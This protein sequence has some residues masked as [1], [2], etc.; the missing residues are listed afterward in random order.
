LTLGTASTTRGTS[1][2]RDT[3]FEVG[4][5]TKLFTGLLL[6]DMAV[7]G[8]LALDDPVSTLLPAGVEPPTRDGREPTLRELSSHMSGL[9]RLPGNLMPADMQDPYAGYTTEAM[10]EFVSG[11]A[12]PGVP[13]ESFEYSNLGVGL[14]GD[15]LTRRAGASYAGLLEDRVTGPLGLDRTHV[16]TSDNDD[17]AAEGHVSGEVV[18]YWHMDAL[19]AAGEVRSTPADMLRFVRAQLDPAGTPL[20]ETIRLT[21]E[22]VPAVDQLSMGLGWHV[23][24]LPDGREIYFHNGGTGGFRSFAGFV[25]GTGVGLVIL[26][27]AAFP[28]EA[29][30]QAGVQMLMAVLQAQ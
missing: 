15:L 25:P 7:R 8:E 10:Y 2:T 19:K 12:L 23:V 26:A 24:A 13:G 30:D 17:T 11:L 14:L 28:L 29:I 1:V 4:S 21:Q 22:T 20:E 16:P 5:I 6:A 18:P 3:R 9:P 27:N